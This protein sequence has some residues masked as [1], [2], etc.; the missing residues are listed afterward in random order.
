MAFANNTYVVVRTIH[1]GVHVGTLVDRRGSEVDLA[2]ARRIWAY[3]DGSGS[4]YGYGDGDGYGY[5]YGYGYGSGSGYGYG[6]GDG[7]G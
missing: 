2:H 4:G 5:G 1:A 3:G 7:D 6:D